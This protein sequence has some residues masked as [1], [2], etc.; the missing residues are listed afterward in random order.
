MLPTSSVPR[1]GIRMPAQ[2]HGKVTSK[3]WT[4][5]I[6]VLLLTGQGEINT[7]LD[8]NP[9]LLGQFYLNASMAGGL[10]VQTCPLVAPAHP[11]M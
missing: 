10:Q 5:C 9:E 8:S 2:V 1:L 11:H 3:G 4:K 6:P 7:P